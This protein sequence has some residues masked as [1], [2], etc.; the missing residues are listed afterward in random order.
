MTYI[1]DYS[2]TCNQMKKKIRSTSFFHYEG[3]IYLVICVL[4]LTILKV[5]YFNHDSTSKN[6]TRKQNGH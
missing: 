6:E 3:I 2:T 1:T 5:I 4:Y